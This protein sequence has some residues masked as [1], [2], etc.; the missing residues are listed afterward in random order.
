MKSSKSEKVKAIVR[1]SC[2]ERR[3]PLGA[4]QQTLT[5]AR[6]LTLNDN[7]AR[8]DSSETDESEN[9]EYDRDAIDS[10]AEYDSSDVILAFI[11]SDEEGASL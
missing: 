7:R 6:T 9:E 10:R 3:S 2:L 4:G 5:N 1:H 11:N 8:A